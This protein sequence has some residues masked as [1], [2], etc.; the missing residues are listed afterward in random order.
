[1]EPPEIVVFH[2]THWKAGSQWVRKLLKDA[3]PDRVIEVR[4]N[5]SHITDEPIRSG[6]VYTPTYLHREYFAET[7]GLHENHRRFV[8]IRDLRDTLVSWYFSLLRSPNAFAENMRKV[9]EPMSKDQ[10]L[11]HLVDEPAF[12][13]NATI[14]STWLRGDDPVFRYED[15]LANELDGFRRIFEHCEFALSDAERD[16]IVEQHNFTRRSGR[17]PGEEDLS[18]HLRKAVAGDWKNHFSPELTAAFN[19]RFGQVLIDTGY[20]SSMDW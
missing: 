18:K 3:V 13:A 15:L 2:I 1:M 5:M 12:A 16:A 11:L 4:E 20:E 17:K 19:S 14:Q 10:A 7:V 9:L 8:V 6:G